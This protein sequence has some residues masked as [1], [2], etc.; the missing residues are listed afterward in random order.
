MVAA[1][2]RHL[3]PADRF[4]SVD[5]Y[6]PVSIRQRG[7]RRRVRRGEYPT[8]PQYQQSQ[9]RLIITAALE[10]STNQ[11][12]HFFSNKKDTEEMIALL[13]VL[14]ERYAGIKAKYERKHLGTDR[15]R[16]RFEF[17][18]G[19]SHVLSPALRSEVRSCVQNC[20]LAATW[21]TEHDQ[22]TALQRSMT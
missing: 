22:R 16:F 20:G 5:E 17:D 19:G 11:I 8:I 18:T 12:T 1:H 13:K 6:G 14:I 7:G 2:R 21:F 10:L 9:G 4:F 15:L 3:G